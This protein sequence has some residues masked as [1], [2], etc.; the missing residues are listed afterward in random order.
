MTESFN[1][2]TK[3][4]I[5][6]EFLDGR[7][8]D[9]STRDALVEAHRLRAIVDPSPLVVAV[10]HRHLLAVLHRVVDGPKTMQEWTAIG[11]TGHFEAAK[12]EGYLARVRERMDLFHPTHPFAQTRGLI[13]RGMPVTSI[14]ELELEHSGW[15]QREYLFQH[16]PEDYTHST[17]PGKAARSLLAHQAFA[18]H[19]TLKGMNPAVGKRLGEPHSTG[20]GA[21]ARSAVIIL[22][23]PTLFET[24]VANL[25]VYDPSAS[26]P[27]PA[28]AEDAPSWEQDPLPPNAQECELTRPLGWLDVLTWL[29]RRAELHSAKGL[30]V[31][32]THA[33]GR[34]RAKDNGVLDPQVTYERNEK[35]GFRPI[36]IRAD[37]AFWRD[38]NAL[39]EATR[40]GQPRFWRPLA[41]DLVA[42]GAGESPFGDGAA[43]AV[44]AFGQDTGSGAKVEADCVR[45]ESLSVKGRLLA[46]PNAREAVEH[47]LRFSD[48]AIRTLR[49][50]LYEFAKLVL[51]MSDDEGKDSRKE[52]WSFVRRSGAETG[53]WAALGAVFESFLRDLGD[54]MDDA[55]QRFEDGTR[56]IVRERFEDA[57]SAELSD[58]RALRARAAAEE[59]LAQGLARLDS[60]DAEAIDG[61]DSE[62]E[63]EP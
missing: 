24:L 31:G 28:S 4:W 13:G 37:R 25:L 22:R 48:G 20:A 5:P 3:P 7:Q 9:L 15:G 26:K 57:L 46:D 19:G 47:V 30:I 59:R 44:E 16:R 12:V 14:D 35:Q 55:R 18:F 54:D 42:P 50:A 62:E 40:K 60:T 61:D 43:Y 1:L 23:R 10:L 21:L 52:R 29:S 17:T 41:I 11:R 32:F 33:A 45:Q 51:P 38:A 8:A 56:K 39:F 27:I 2:I 53:S 34:G 63:D 6:C 36:A 58:G 49:L